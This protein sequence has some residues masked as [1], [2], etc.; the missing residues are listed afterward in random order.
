MNEAVQRAATILKALE[1]QARN[2]I[3]AMRE[4]QSEP[5]FLLFT[6]RVQALVTIYSALIVAEQ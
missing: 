4:T 6:H 3:N 5:R 2:D 1:Q